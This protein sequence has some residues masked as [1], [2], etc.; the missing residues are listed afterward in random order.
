MSTT[1][2]SGGQSAATAS[3]KD[4]DEDRKRFL[5]TVLE[6]PM[7]MWDNA[8]VQTMCGRY[9]KHASLHGYKD[10]FKIDLL[11]MLAVSRTEP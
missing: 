2:A 8:T 3:K 4:K 6:L 10:A 7:S 5:T 1:S 11:R 9:V